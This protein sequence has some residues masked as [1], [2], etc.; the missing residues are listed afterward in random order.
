MNLVLLFDSDFVESDCVVRL[1]GRRMLHMM[2]V[3]KV[4][5]GNRIKVGRLNGKIGHGIV[6][7]ISNR[8]IELNVSLNSNPPPPL[9]VTLV[10]ALPR[11]K[12]LKKVLQCVTAMGVKRIFLIRTWRVEKSYF[13]SPFISDKNLLDQFILGLEQGCDTIVP[14]CEIK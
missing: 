9:P 1:E 11:P 4:Q 6:N 14:S 3:H 13:D 7:D 2:T 5:K 8:Y 12:T 10:L